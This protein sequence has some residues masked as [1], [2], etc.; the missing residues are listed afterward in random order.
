MI[1]I[2]GK[3]PK[4]VTLESERTV[5]EIAA[6]LGISEVNFIFMLNGKP[7]TSDRIVKKDDSLVMME[8]FSGG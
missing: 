4:K 2:V 1:E 7:V 3:N 5:A 8:V 6:E